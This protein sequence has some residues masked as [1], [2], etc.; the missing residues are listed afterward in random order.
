MKN[1][2]SDT[3]RWQKVLM[4]EADTVN[5]VGEFQRGAVKALKRGPQPFV[6]PN[7]M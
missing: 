4:G 6:G 2:W 3:R 5:I 7:M 1:A